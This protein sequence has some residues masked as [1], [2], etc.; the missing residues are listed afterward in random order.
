MS[1]R[2]NQRGVVLFEA[3]LAITLLVLSVLTFF[4]L[5]NSGA[6]RSET[7][8]AQRNAVA[9][10]DNVLATLRVLSEENARANNWLGF[11]KGFL[12]TEEETR[13]V[14][15]PAADAWSN[16]VSGTVP[17]LWANPGGLPAGYSSNPWATNS[18]LIRFRFA[19]A[20][21]DCLHGIVETNRSGWYRYHAGTEADTAQTVARY[22]ISA[23]FQ[24]NVLGDTDTVAV[25]VTAWPGAEAPMTAENEVRLYAEF[26]ESGAL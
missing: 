1:P 23:Q 7:A 13:A 10:A 11:W 14:F 15:A 18:G 25:V 21:N 6:R 9:L 26:R 20:S 3:L 24:T 17:M 16:M 5:F 4:F 22:R 8:R 2:A 12:N 19:Y